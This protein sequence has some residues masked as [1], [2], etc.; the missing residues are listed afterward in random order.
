MVLTGTTARAQRASEN[1]VTEADDAFGTVVGN[2]VIGLYT[3]ILARGF[4][5]SQAG[6]LRI[7]GLYFDQ[8]VAPN[9]RIQRGSSIHVGISA[10]GYAF[11]APTGVVDFDLRAPGDRAVVSVLAGHA[12]VLSY[13]RHQLE[14]DAQIPVAAGVFSLGVG[15]GYNHNNAHEN[16]VRDEGYNLG[17]IAK[18]T[19]SDTVTVIPFWS[20]NK[21]GAIGGDRPRIFIGDNPPPRFRA[22]D[23]LAPEWL[24]FGFRQANFGVVSTFA[25]GDQWNLEAGLFRSINNMPRVYNALLL[26]TN[27]AGEGNLIIEQTPPRYTRS[28]SGEVKLSKSFVEN[29]RRHTVFFMGRGRDRGNTFGGGEVKQF[30]RI[31]IGNF[32]VNIPEPVY[33]TGPVSSTETKQ[34]T[35]GLG[36]EGVWRGVGQIS[37]GLQ[38]TDYKRTQMRPGG[39]VVGSHDKPWLYNAGAAAYLTSKLALYAG[40]TR[41]IEEIGTAPSNA[42]N[43]DEG[44][45]AT[46]TRQIDAG[47]RYQIR[48]NLNFVAGVFQI[49][50]PYYS[51]DRALLF[52]EL[53]D[54]R[55]RGVEISFAGAVTETLTVVAGSVLIQPRI[56][57]VAVAGGTTRLTAVGPIPRLIRVNL[58]Y[59]PPIVRGLVLDGKIESI[60]SRYVTASNSQRV[61]GALTFDAGFRYTTTIADVPVRFR[62]QGL[63]LT[64]AYTLTPN[65]SG[66]VN[67]FEERRFDFNITADF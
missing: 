8:A 32:P 44:V 46:L 12:A 29:D 61:K 24:Y 5:P 7:N 50:K 58:Q 23:L 34:L 26:G 11:P 63:N 51:V 67:A 42:A 10:Q 2:E 65:A 4:N 55:H 1:A 43:R 21:S 66:Q 49:D 19:P 52:R 37:L 59:R 33:T 30:G 18:W 27:S 39:V 64:N 16:A 20:R 17:A 22:E 57:T 6:N 3:T 14:V 45:P 62:L 54:V 47:V 13:P 53:G 35:G 15:A 56:S 48:P 25:L 9:L 41:G 31:R 60:S 28:T 36:Y 38:K 40:Y